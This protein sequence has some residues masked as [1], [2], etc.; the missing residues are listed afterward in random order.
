MHAAPWAGVVSVCPASQWSRAS[1][2]RKAQRDH[3]PA[4]SVTMAFPTG[5]VAPVTTQT[6][7]YCSIVSLVDMYV[8]LPTTLRLD[9]THE[10]AI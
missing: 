7:P 8:E 9:F 6:N 1:R 4:S 3:P 2:A 5:C 10:L